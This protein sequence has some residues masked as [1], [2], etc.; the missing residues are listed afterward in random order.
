MGNDGS[1]ENQIMAG[2]SES[3]PLPKGWVEWI[4]PFGPDNEPVYMRV[5]ETTAI[6][7]MKQQHPYATDADALDDFIVVHWALRS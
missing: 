7:I 2:F 5:P 6:A 1:E 4:E 3:G